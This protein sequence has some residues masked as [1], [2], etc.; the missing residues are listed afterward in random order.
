MVLGDNRENSAD[1]RFFGVVTR[2]RILGA[3]IFR[4]WPPKEVGFF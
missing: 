4:F 1:S 2:D 3:V